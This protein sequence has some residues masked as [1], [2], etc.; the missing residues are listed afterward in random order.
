MAFYLLLNAFA[1][2]SEAARLWIGFGFVWA[3]IRHTAA[4]SAAVCHS[5]C[6][7][8]VADHMHGPSTGWIPSTRSLVRM[9]VKLHRFKVESI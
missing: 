4:T 1:L 7:A 9:K 6:Q 3:Q 8:F 2:A 5:N